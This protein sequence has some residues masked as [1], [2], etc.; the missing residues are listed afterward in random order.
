MK[1]KTR[2]SVILVMLVCFFAMLVITDTTCYSIGTTYDDDSQI[3]E[4]NTSDDEANQLEL[5]KSKEDEF[6]N[7]D[8]IELFSLEAEDNS[9]DDL[10]ASNDTK[11]TSKRNETKSNSALDSNV[12]LKKDLEQKVVKDN[13]EQKAIQENLE[14]KAIQ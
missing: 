7:M 11:E 4:T 13:L 3:A 6:A 1:A 10:I 9:S 5:A 2:V 12:T 8:K 14:Q